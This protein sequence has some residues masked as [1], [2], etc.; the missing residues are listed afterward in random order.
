MYKL[1][2]DPE[3]EMHKILLDFEIQTDYLI[4]DKRS[5][6]ELILK[7][8]RIC[9]LMDFVIPVKHRES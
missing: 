7:K 3:S 5:D 8:K 1:E 4:P 2:S 9:F 6:Q